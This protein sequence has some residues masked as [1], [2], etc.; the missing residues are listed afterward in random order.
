MRPL[1]ILYN[2]LGLTTLIL[3]AGKYKKRAS[4]EHSKNKTPVLG[5]A[6]TVLGMKLKRG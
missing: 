3:I 5:H 2:N 4:F 6:I 1:K